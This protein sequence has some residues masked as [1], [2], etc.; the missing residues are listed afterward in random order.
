MLVRAVSVSTYGLR[1]F[2]TCLL[3]M[4]YL[5]TFSLKKSTQLTFLMKKKLITTFFSTVISFEEI[6]VKEDLLENISF[7]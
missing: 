7:T 1:C 5:L 4:Y 2:M 6:P 3:D